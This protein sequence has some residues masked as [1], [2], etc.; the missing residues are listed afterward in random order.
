MTGNSPLC[1]FERSRSRV[2][3]HQVLDHIQQ[4]LGRTECM[5]RQRSVTVSSAESAHTTSFY[6]HLDDSNRGTEHNK[7][8]GSATVPFPPGMCSVAGSWSTKN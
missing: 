1:S 8:S 7:H 2:G 5:Q 3:I 6:E 4:G